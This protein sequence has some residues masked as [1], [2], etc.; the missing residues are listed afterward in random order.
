MLK[1]TLYMYGVNYALLDPHTRSA[2]GGLPGQQGPDLRLK[3]KENFAS[4]GGAMA[5]LTGDQKSNSEL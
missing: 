2:C 3:Q 4:D 5:F 1:F